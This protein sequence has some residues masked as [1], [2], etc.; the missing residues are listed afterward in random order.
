M[1]LAGRAEDARR[2]LKELGSEAQPEVLAALGDRDATFAAISGALD[3][4]QSW[5]LFIKG[6]PI[7]ESLHGD[8]RW[9]G[10]LQRMN[11]EN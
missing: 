9:T 7:F 8:P 3:R 5:L 2:L 4:R 1:A 10:I 11:L 6:D